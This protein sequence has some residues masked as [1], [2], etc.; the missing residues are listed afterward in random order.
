V[1]TRP[2]SARFEELDWRR[3]PMG[4]LSLRRRRETVLDV[5]VYEVRLGEEFLMSSLFTVAEVEL[6]RLGLAL[7]PGTDLDVV[8]GGLGLGF[9]ARAALADSRVRSLHVVEAQ[10]AVIEWHQRELLPG[11]AELVADPRCRLDLGDFFA[12]VRGEGF[13]P[14]APSRWH[15]VLVDID[16]TPD[17]LLHPSHAEFYT[18]AGLTQLTDCLHPAGVFG[19]WSDQPPDD[20]FLGLLRSAFG[21]AEARVVSFPNHYTGEQS[22]NTVYLATLPSAPPRGGR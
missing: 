16:H 18:A 6:A 17:H 19:L 21:R 2:M 14:D 4:E 12:A 15:V 20:R 5:D 7:A 8:V 10:A 1:K 3:T 9:T 11:A 13:G 22:A